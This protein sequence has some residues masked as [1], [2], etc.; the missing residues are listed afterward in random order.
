VNPVSRSQAECMVN[1]IAE[2]SDLRDVV[3]R[4]VAVIDQMSDTG[5]NA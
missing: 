5:Q 1:V 4:R 2:H 3:E